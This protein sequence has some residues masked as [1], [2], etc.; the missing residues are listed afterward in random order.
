[1]GRRLSSRESL[2]LCLHTLKGLLLA[3]LAEC[4]AEDDSSPKCLH[5]RQI[6]LIVSAVDGEEY[7]ASE[8][9]VRDLLGKSQAGPCW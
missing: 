7:G 5:P 8:M 2:H 6:L 1:M 4:V 3:L 9:F